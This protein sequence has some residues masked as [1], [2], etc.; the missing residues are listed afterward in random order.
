MLERDLPNWR[1]RNACPACTYKLEDKPTLTF[2]MLVT[3]DGNDSLK[4]V[5]RR[6][7]P[8]HSDEGNPITTGASR[9][10]SDK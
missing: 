6:D 7:I 8:E 2:D 1:L 3:M 5:I 9:E 4:R 10:V